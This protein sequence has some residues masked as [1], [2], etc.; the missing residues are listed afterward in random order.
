MV[1][2][3]QPSIS[4][5]C[6]FTIFPLSAPAFYS[7][8]VFPDALPSRG[9]CDNTVLDFSFLLRT[10]AAHTLDICPNESRDEHVSLLC[11]ALWLCNTG[12]QTYALPILPFAACAIL[13]IRKKDCVS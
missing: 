8:S 6:L 9:N 1:N 12:T 7:I 11:T 4:L 13:L 10:P 3:V 2:G 5:I